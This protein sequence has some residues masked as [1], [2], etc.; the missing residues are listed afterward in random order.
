MKI[1]TNL[2]FGIID[3]YHRFLGPVPMSEINI[4]EINEYGFGHAPPG[5]M[6]TTKEAF[7]HMLGEENQFFSQ[8]INERFAHEIAHQYWGT[9]VKMPSEEETGMP[10]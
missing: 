8:G 1:L 5:T 9:A 7:N 4:L 3:Y 2:A 6:F 10:E